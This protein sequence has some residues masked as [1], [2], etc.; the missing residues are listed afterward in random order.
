MTIPARQVMIIADEDERSMYRNLRVRDW[1]VRFCPCMERNVLSAHYRVDLVLIDCGVHVDLGVLILRKIKAL[2]HDV[3]VIFLTAVSSEDTVIAAY[4]AGARDYFRK[5][6][7]PLELREKVEF[8]L[9]VT[10]RSEQGV[11]LFGNT[12]SAA[13]PADLP[14]NLLRT[15]RYMAEHLTG[16]VSLDTLAREACLSRF[17]FCRT[18][19]R[20]V[21]MSPIQ[22]VLTLRVERAKYLL[23]TTDLT[24]SMVAIKVG[25]GHI[26][27]FIRQFKK[28]TGMTPTA[29]KKFSTDGSS[30]PK[31]GR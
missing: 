5:P 11:L 9:A 23:L 12:A 24:I 16:D 4:K 14:V 1:Q 21:G 3:P 7:D 10:D 13:L 31:T 22:F 8:L 2:W 19:K 27:D 6:V 25:C 17:H 20:L 28:L 30:P 15:I 26:S 29:F 18:F